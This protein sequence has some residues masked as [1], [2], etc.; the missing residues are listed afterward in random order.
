MRHRPAPLRRLAAATLLAVFL[1]GIAL[2]AGPFTLEQV[3]SYAYPE[4][5]IAARKAPRIAWTFDDAGRRNVWVAEG[6]PLT[7][8]QLTAY[9]ADDGQEITSLSI[10]ADG[11]RLVYVRG[12]EHGG[13]WD[14]SVPVNVLSDPAG[15]KVEIWAVEWSGGAPRLIGEGDY[16]VV[17]PDGQRIAYLKGEEVWVASLQGEPQPR[18]MFSARGK[19]QSP[20]WSPDG[21]ELAFVSSRG[22]HAIIGV[23][24]G[25]G[26]PIRWIAPSS[27]KDD[28]PRWSP[29][30]RQIAFVRRPGTGGT[31]S[32][33]LE[34]EREPWEL[35]VADAVTGEAHRRY[36]GEPIADDSSWGLYADWGANGR[37]VFRSYQDGWP[38]L[39]S[40]GQDGRPL[41][42]TP[43]EFEV[44][45]VALSPDRRF[46]VYSANTG[47]DPKD[48]ERRHLF[49]VPVDAAKPEALTAGSGLEWTPVV[50]SDGRVAF[51]SA[52]SQRTPVP[53]TRG[54]GGRIERLAGLPVHP[55]FPES[56]LVTPE[57]VMFK[58]ADGFPIHA[59]L[60]R[61]AR[62][63]G[64]RP[65]VVYVHGGPSRQ[66]LLGWHYMGYYSNDYAMN[67]YL[68]SRG[69]VVLAVNYRLGIGYGRDSRFPDKAGPRGA[70]EYHDVQAAG[71][72]LQ[73]LPDVDAARVGIYGGS[74]GGYLTAM[75]LARDS[76]LFAAGVDIHGVHDW[77]GQGEM[78][79]LL[80]R[81]RYEEAPDLKAALDA[82]WASSPASDVSRWKSP[83]LFIHGDDDRNVDVA[84]TV[85]LV[86]R[87]RKTGVH[88]EEMILVDE[89]HSIQRYSN[90][91]RMNAAV[92]E[93]LERYL[94][95]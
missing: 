83:V 64:K 69:F 55:E 68:A 18:K 95:P 26:T 79:S 74:Y 50:V 65:A 48:T 42:L 12:G 37:I 33:L 91:L 73:S 78:D 15:T 32:L 31:P 5:L 70:S 39:Y 85:D 75:A 17:S 4:S 1:P 71:R 6:T 61:P 66:M 81:T 35:W 20:A 9:S 80:R 38:Q 93:F 21:R 94:K 58:S 7:A 62:G 57:P 10:S 28:A 13:N 89:T 84:Q 76:A 67:Q 22:N 41:K 60:F 16:P 44:E 86:Q 43:G 25:D 82:A 24:A 2:A 14:N 54:A 11:T 53:A 92:A 90:V 87:L 47:S 34:F 46:I 36:A 3:R 49:K 77:V 51:V 29:D 40:V 56:A 59:Q 88:Q 19:S 72:Y 45:D 63:A 23:F 27:S 52:T 8:R 30:G